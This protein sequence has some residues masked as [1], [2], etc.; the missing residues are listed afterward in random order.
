MKIKINHINDRSG[1]YRPSLQKVIRLSYD[2]Y[3]I[4]SL[5][6]D[7]LIWVFD[8]L[9]E[10]EALIKMGKPEKRDY[11]ASIILNVIFV[12]ILDGLKF[13]KSKDEKVALINLAKF[14]GRE[15]LPGE[16]KDFRE[17]YSG[18]RAIKEYMEEDVFRDIEMALDN[19]L[20]SK[21]ESTGE[22]DKKKKEIAKLH[23]GI[24]KRMVK[25]GGRRNDPFL[26]A[27]LYKCYCAFEGNLNQIKNIKIAQF[28]DVI[29]SKDFICGKNIKD[30][31]RRRLDYLLQPTLNKTID[32][33]IT[34][35]E[36]QWNLMSHLT[37]EDQKFIK[38]L[39]NTLKC[40]SCVSMFETKI[41][42]YYTQNQS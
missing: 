7:Y 35:L 33:K 36:N 1:T 40:Y 8:V 4:K 28:V 9:R 41:R 37:I 15:F 24:Q 29:Y 16:L 12:C 19:D 3:P 26:N 27:I 22:L 6:D 31:V 21:A 42:T 32:Q 39:M 2:D 5:P 18:L 25:T 38:E 17:K 34:V 10:G 20:I 13:T 23:Q 14:G 11:R 30:L